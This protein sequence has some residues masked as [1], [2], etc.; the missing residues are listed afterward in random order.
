V[1]F[2]CSED[3]P[4]PNE[5][6]HARRIARVVTTPPPAP[7][8]AGAFHTAVEVVGPHALADS[9]PFVLLMDDRL[10]AGSGTRVGGAHPHA[11]LETVT[12][13]LAGTIRDRDEGELG[14]GDAVW[15][16]AGRGIIHNESVEARGDARILQLWIGLPARL[17]DEPPAFEI[18]H[19]DDVPT[20]REPGVVARLYSGRSGELRSP[21]HN[22][23]PITLVDVELQPG[24]SFVQ[25]LSAREN[26]FL[27]VVDGSLAVGDVVL[28]AGQVGW[29]D[30]RDDLD[31]TVLEIAA[32]SAGARSVLYAGVPQ[33]EAL[34][35]HGPF[36]A[37]SEREV[38]RMYGEFRAGRFTPMSTL[39][40]RGPIA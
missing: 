6:L 32:T 26:G 4:M 31:P 24:A 16:T 14:P 13:V 18:I 15:M 40:P 17:R 37:G 19:R 30:R 28:G 21:T 10:A 35:Q 25:Q 36:V 1:T 7:G 3:F 12:L 11:G 23:V 20:R 34:V 38:A 33:Q 39:R 5:P 27:Y 8:F 29:L 22:H 9:D 2:G